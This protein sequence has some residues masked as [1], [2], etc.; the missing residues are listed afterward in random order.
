[1]AAP[2]VTDMASPT[3][4]AGAAGLA[5]LLLAPRALEPPRELEVLPP[6]PDCMSWLLPL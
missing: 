6:P 3:E 4:V 2:H 1:M 5:L